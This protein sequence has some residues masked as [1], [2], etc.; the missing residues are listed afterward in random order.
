MKQKRLIEEPRIRTLGLDPSLRHGALVEGVWD[1]RDGVDLKETHVVARWDTPRRQ[2]GVLHA[3]STSTEIMEFSNWLVAQVAQRNH[4]KGVPIGVD[5]HPMSVFWGNRK[6][7]LK[8]TFFMGYLCRALQT[9]GCPVVFIEPEE[10]R[11]AFGHSRA[12]TKEEVWESIPFFSDATDSDE[13]D[14]LILAYL[15][16]EGL[17]QNG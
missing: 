3:E 4:L 16:A 11:V 6:A 12:L 2:R 9:L 13:R 17:R 8:L 10:V 15:V 14:A 7:G 5:W 1:F